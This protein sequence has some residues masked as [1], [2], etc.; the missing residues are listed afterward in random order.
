[1][2]YRNYLH[3]CQHCGI[4]HATSSSAGPKK[5]VLCDARTF[6]EYEMNGLLEERRDAEPRSTAT[7][8]ERVTE[9]LSSVTQP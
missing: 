5:C 1:M 6:S 8:E 7:D 4:V 9:S 2:G 3:V